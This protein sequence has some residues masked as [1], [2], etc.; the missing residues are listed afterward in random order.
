MVFAGALLV[1]KQVANGNIVLSLRASTQVLPL[2]RPQAIMKF[3]PHTGCEK[4]EQFCQSKENLI[5]RILFPNHRSALVR[6]LIS[7]K[8]FTSNHGSALGRTL[9]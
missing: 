7:R 4:L 5:P 2:I 9:I 3:S 1:S 8:A 6:M